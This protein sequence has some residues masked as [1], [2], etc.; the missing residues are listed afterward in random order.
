MD[1]AQHVT[2]AQSKLDIIQPTAG[3]LCVRLTG[4]WTIYATLPS[5]EAVQ[6]ELA[7]LPQVRR[8]IFET[9]KLTGWDSGLLTFLLKLK[10]LCTERQVECDPA[11]LPQGVQ[12][13]LALATAVPEHHE[14]QRQGDQESLVVQVGQGGLAPRVAEQLLR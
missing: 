13:L 7:A 8:L 5:M 6:A 1:A 11:G 2:Q 14:D 4:Q 12:R 9:Q 3:T 10:D